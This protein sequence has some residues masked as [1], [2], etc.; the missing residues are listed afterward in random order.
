MRITSQNK[1]KYSTFGLLAVLAVGFSFPDAAAHVTS[2]I[3]HTLSHVMDTLTG[4]DR[5]VDALTRTMDFDIQLSPSNEDETILAVADEFQPYTKLGA[6]LSFSISGL[7][8]DQLILTCGISE[9]PSL[10]SSA[11]KSFNENGEYTIDAACSYFIFRLDA[12][13][14]GQTVDTVDI[15][16]NIIYDVDAT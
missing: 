7:S 3:Q 16:G 4:I 2:N 11:H 15:Q 9:D 12:I 10:P 5:K 14:K 13:G 8:E 6:T 1:W